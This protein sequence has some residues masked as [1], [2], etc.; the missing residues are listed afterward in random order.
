[1]QLSLSAT[2]TLFFAVAKNCSSCVCS[3]RNAANE[4]R[5]AC[6]QRLSTWPTIGLYNFVSLYSLL[7]NL[8][9]HERINTFTQQVVR[10]SFAQ[11]CQYETLL[12]YF[13]AF[14]MLIE[15]HWLEA[16]SSDIVVQCV[17]PFK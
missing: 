4:R 12:R 2:N 1:M 17:F 16:E 14:G 6:A 7:Q 5:I 13:V 9:G 3:N 11:C 10:K 15:I 8:L